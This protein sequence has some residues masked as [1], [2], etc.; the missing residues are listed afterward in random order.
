M[1]R[2]VQDNSANVPFQGDE[3]PAETEKVI[4]EHERT[5]LNYLH[6]LY[7]AI[8][9]NMLE[10][11]ELNNILSVLKAF[12]EKN[13]ENYLFYLMQPEIS[14]GCKLPSP[15]PV[16]S[17]S[18]QLHN[19]ITLTTNPS[20]NLVFT[21]NPF[22]LY[23]ADSLP[24]KSI[25]VTGGTF[26]A[27][28]LTSAFLGNADEIDGSTEQKEVME[29]NLGQGIPGVYS[30]YRVVS[31]S[32]VVR[33]IGR[34]DIASGVVGGAIIFDDSV[35]S[36]GAYGTMTPTSGDPEELRSRS[37]VLGKYA[38]FDLSQD[39]FYHVEA[40]SLKGMR[41]LYFPIDNSFEEYQPVFDF[42]KLKMKY[43]DSADT[44][45]YEFSAADSSDYKKGF[46]M[47]F[48]SLGAPAS[49]ACFKVDIYVNYECIPNPKFLNYMPISPSE[50]A[51]SSTMK[52]EYVRYVQNKPITEADERPAPPATESV[53]KSLKRKFGKYIPSIVKTL[54]T[55]LETSLPFLKPAL[56]IAG[57]MISGSTPMETE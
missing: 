18:F 9:G 8:N 4:N 45:Y 55:G 24:G 6:R 53:F 46:N 38:N 43:Y 56:S 37:F 27:T 32:M 52:S 5:F 31:G 1:F 17:S 34:M 35:D 19:S 13:Q 50:P 57:S 30:S 41:E 42:S 7:W 39:S 29:I 25:P 11:D 21:F 14:K 2:K 40:M 22:F 51:I 47:L 26:S 49:S 36:I 3:L 28:H 12:N 20:G 15:M 10:I 48:Y 33:Y 23:N 54:K 44:G 16:P